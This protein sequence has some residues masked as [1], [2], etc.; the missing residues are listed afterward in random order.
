MFGLSG[1]N[2]AGAAA[3]L[4]AFSRS[5]AM[6]EFKPDGTIITANENFLK[7]LGYE[8]SDIAGKHHSMFISA[9]DRDT[10][11]YKA[12]W[13]DLASGKYQAG[14]FLR[15]GKG[16]KEVWIQASYNPVYTGSGKTTKVV[17]IATDVTVQKQHT[18]DIEG[19]IA[20]I[21]KSQAV[22]HFNLDGT[23]IEANENFLNALGYRQE[24]IKGKHHSMFVDPAEV[25]GPEY[26]AFWA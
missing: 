1:S 5:Q 26:K 6:I 12:F 8:L 23:I 25:S 15:I 10:P 19:Q 24:E 11:Q 14:E 21:D 20:A 3:V 16:G 17:K 18:A 7:A 13:S 9:E 4:E 22:I 2:S